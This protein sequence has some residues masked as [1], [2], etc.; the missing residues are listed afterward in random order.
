MPEERRGATYMS[1]S[2]LAIELDVHRNSIIK[3]IKAGNILAYRRGLAP[4][5]PYLIPMDEADR[6]IEEFK[7]G[8]R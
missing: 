1:V 6:V 2:E 4:K 3:W 7:N 5:S 8:V